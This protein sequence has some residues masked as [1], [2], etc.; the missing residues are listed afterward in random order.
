MF[1]SIK[2]L[3]RGF[4]QAEM[5]SGRCCGYIETKDGANL[6]AAKASTQ[7]WTSLCGDPM[8]K[9]ETPSPL[10]S[11]M[12][13]LRRTARRPEPEG[14]ELGSRNGGVCGGKAILRTVITTTMPAS[15]LEAT[16]REG[17]PIASRRSRRIESPLVMPVLL[18]CSSLRV[19]RFFFK[20]L[21]V[22]QSF[23]MVSGVLRRWAFSSLRVVS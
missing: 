8:A 5:G 12:R 4:P 2:K 9:S 21:I 23:A 6:V 3:G 1:S 7:P 15:A 18:P 10:K 14:K 22:A 13:A 17:T 16:S 19:V 11:R 20:L